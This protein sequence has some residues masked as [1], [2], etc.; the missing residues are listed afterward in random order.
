MKSAQQEQESRKRI[1]SWVGLIVS[2]VAALFA[3]W[4]V[5][6]NRREVNAMEAQIRPIVGNVVL[7]SNLSNDGEL[8]VN[9]EVY[10]VGTMPASITSFFMGFGV[11]SGPSSSFTNETVITVMPYQPTSSHIATIMMNVLETFVETPVALFYD[12]RIEYTG[13]RRSGDYSYRQEGRY[14]PKKNEWFMNRSES[15]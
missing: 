6:E 2:I 10:N 14:D 4:S 11:D 9:V 7:V 15:T 1:L 13:P 3:G 8:E 5:L 12:F